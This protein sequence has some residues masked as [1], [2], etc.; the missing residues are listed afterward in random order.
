MT[1]VALGF[2]LTGLV[3]GVYAML[4]GTERSVQPAVAPHERRSEHNPAAEPSPTL[5]LASLAAFAVGFGL[6]GYLL[7][8]ANEWAWYWQLLVALG[9]GGATY[10]LQSLLIARWA[11]PG[12]RADHVDER[13]LLQGTLAHITQAVAG[14]G[15]GQLR[16]ALDGREYLLPAQSMDDSALALGTDVVIDRVEEGV[17]YAEPWDAVERRL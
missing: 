9:A 17:A 4:Y 11:I 14:G 12:A 15:R 13:Y 10:A 2:L 6:T 16:Y 7:T 5:N 1:V 8:R 3:L